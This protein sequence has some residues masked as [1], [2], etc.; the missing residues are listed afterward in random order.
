MTTEL[1]PR[2]GLICP[3]SL[4]VWGGVQSQVLGLA[5]SLRRLGVPTQ[6]LAPCDGLPPEPW[7]TPLGDSIPYAENG[8]VAPL[9]PDPAAQLRLLGAVWDERF[10]ILHLHEPLA[11]GPTLTS[12]VV[13][14]TPLIGTFHASGSIRP[15]RWINGV[16]RRLAQ[17]LDQ[18]VA[19]STE[20]A[21][22]ASESLGGDYRIV[23]NAVEVDRFVGA[24]PWPTTGPTVMFLGRHEERKGLHVL[25]EA[26]R[27]L[28]QDVTF[29]IAGKGPDTPALQARF[30]SDERIQ[31]LGAVDD[32]EKASR[33][34]GVDVFCAPA[35]GGESFGV[36]LLEGMAAR[37]AVVASDIPAFRSVTQDGR[38]ATLFENQSSAAL[39]AALR[40][41]LER[42]PAILE[43][44]DAA[45]RRADDNSMAAQAAVYLDMYNR[46]LS[47]GPSANHE[48]S[49]L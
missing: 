42:G 2:V 31:W 49:R 24:P 19:V 41:A 13:K 20:A 37:T 22:T 45:A 15:Y 36:V 10:D 32:A 25:L 38:C 44:L 5:R 17:R 35:Q 30:G 39:A 28:D 34:A 47:A 7:V 29:W 12:L 43:Q 21:R 26:A 16:V 9:A 46:Q 23:A 3:Y 14:P 48:R 27:Y 11:P 33:L 6:V 1:P 8:S 40:V 4:G 18:R